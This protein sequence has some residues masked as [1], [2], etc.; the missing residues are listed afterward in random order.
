MTAILMRFSSMLEGLAKKYPNELVLVR[1]QGTLK[2]TQDVMHWVNELHP[3][4]AFLRAPRESLTVF[5]SDAAGPMRRGLR[6]TI[7]LTRPLCVGQAPSKLKSSESF[8]PKDHSA[9]AFRGWR[10]GSTPAAVVNASDLDGYAWT[11]GL[12]TVSVAYGVG[13]LSMLNAIAGAYVER[14]PVVVINGGPTLANLSNL[15]KYDV[16]FSH[17][18]GQDATDLTVFKQVNAKAGRAA[19][20]AEVPQFVDGAIST[21]LKT[22]RPVYVEISKDIWRSTCPKP[23]GSIVGTNRP[24][25]TERQLAA[26]IVR[27]I[28]AGPSSGAWIEA[29]EMLQNR[30]TGRELAQCPSSTIIR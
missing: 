12:G 29:T 13:T 6:S 4:N 16:V 1:T 25:G 17:S 19:T 14:S 5:R 2:P 8:A 10:H 30:G 21:A 18:T 15:K 27:L 22:K 23:I 26:T 9:T 28:R 3:Y 11:K 20:V 7:R 24:A